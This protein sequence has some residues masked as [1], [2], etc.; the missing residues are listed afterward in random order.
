MS[1]TAER[2]QAIEAVTKY[3]PIS[4]PLSFSKI[5]TSEL[6]GSNV[7]SRAVMKSRLPKPVY[8]SLMR[9]I[10]EGSLLVMPTTFPGA[11]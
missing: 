1:G 4:E 6:F 9:T 2:L 10:D 11:T 3:K 5:S 8:Q 7:F